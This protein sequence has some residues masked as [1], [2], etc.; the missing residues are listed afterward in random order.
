MVELY[1]I[2]AVNKCLQK[3]ARPKSTG[4]CTTSCSL[5]IYTYKLYTGET[6]SI[7]NTGAAELSRQKALNL[8][9]LDL[10]WFTV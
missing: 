2:R 9:F 10:P 1:E 5:L 4:C 7:Q 3:T 6:F 8:E